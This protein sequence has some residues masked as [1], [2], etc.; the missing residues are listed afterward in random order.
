MTTDSHS[1]QQ[2]ADTNGIENVPSDI[3]LY[4]RSDY[5]LSIV[6]QKDARSVAD[7]LVVAAR[8]KASADRSRPIYF[9]DLNA[10]SP[11]TARETAALLTEHAPAVKFIDGGII[12]GPP[13]LQPDGSWFR[14]KLVVSGPVRLDEAER[15]G[16]HFAETLNL[17][18]IGSEIGSA[19]GLKMCFASLFKGFAAIATQSFT[20]AHQLGIAGEL[21][22]LLEEY[23]PATAVQIDKLV[24]SVPPKAYRW[25]QEMLE[26]ADTFEEDGG[27]AADESI[28]RPISRQYDFMTHKTVLGQE[29][30]ENRKH[31]KTVEDVAAV[32]AKANNSR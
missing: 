7:R 13:K 3:D 17:K 20:T 9:L 30:T 19:S 22:G 29:Q 25:V 32:L 24:P 26:I 2:R 14:P 1:T 15:N 4:E 11:K 23:S 31:G 28:F 16:A 12:S 5:I 8:D 18:H 6:P 27:F 21:H 10:V